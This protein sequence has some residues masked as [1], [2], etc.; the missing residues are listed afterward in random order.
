MISRPTIKTKTLNSKYLYNNQLANK[1]ILK[2]II[3]SYFNTYK[4]R[5]NKTLKQIHLG[6]LFYENT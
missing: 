4:L 6:N 3:A 2:F 1:Y 5:N